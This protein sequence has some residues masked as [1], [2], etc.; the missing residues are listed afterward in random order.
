MDNSGYNKLGSCPKEVPGGHWG[1]WELWSRKSLLV[2]LAVVVGTV[3]WALILSILLSKASKER[4]ELLGHQDLLRTNASR[5]AEELGVLQKNL[6]ACTT[7]CSET[8]AQLKTTRAELGE[9]RKKLLEQGS[10]LNDLRERVTKDVSQAGRDREDVRSELLRALEAADL[11]NNSCEPCPK[12][13]VLFQGSC[14]LFSQQQ[15]Y[16]GQAQ[17]SC[18]DA[19]AHLVMVDSWEEQTFLSQNTSGLGFWLG[20]KAE[21]LQGKI[22]GYQWMDGVHRTFS[23]WNEGEPNDSRGVENCVMMLHTGLWNDAPCNLRDN[24]I[25]EKKHGC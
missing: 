3:L 12:S 23:H 8:K 13:W 20:L 4:E 19:G 16:W 2:A 24:W 7:C 18:A 17:K 14:Y 25:C 11:G 6:G 10:A 21:R 1:P 22:Q 15:N 5:Q 9:A